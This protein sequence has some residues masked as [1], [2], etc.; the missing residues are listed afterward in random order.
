MTFPPGRRFGGHLNPAVT[1][2][3][4]RLGAFPAC[5]VVPYVTAQLGGSAAEA[6]LNRLVW[7]RKFPAFPSAT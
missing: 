2:V 3:L 7:D 6:A 1:D 5:A 4:W